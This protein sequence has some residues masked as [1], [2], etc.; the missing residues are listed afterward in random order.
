MTPLKITQTVPS[1]KVV[2]TNHPMRCTTCD[3]NLG[4]LVE[5]DK[6]S[7]K[8]NKIVKYQCIHEQTCGESFVVKS[9]NECYFVPDE[10]LNITGSNIEYLP[11]YIKYTITVGKKC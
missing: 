8:F 10:N 11:T 3:K 6:I 1:K 2:S 7:K 4:T 5:S 9:E